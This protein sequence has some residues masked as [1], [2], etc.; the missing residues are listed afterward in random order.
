MVVYGKVD[1]AVAKTRDKAVIERLPDEF[2]QSRAFADRGW[3][4]QVEQVAQANNGAS[5]KQL[6][7][8]LADLTSVG[9]ANATTPDDDNLTAYDLRRLYYF[10]GILE[11]LKSANLIQFDSVKLEAV[12]AAIRATGSPDFD[13]PPSISKTSVREVNGEYATVL[14]TSSYSA[15]ISVEQLKRVLY[16]VN[17]P[18]VS[19]FFIEMT[20]I[21][22][23]THDSHGWLQLVEVIGTGANAGFQ[24]RTPLKFWMGEHN[25]TAFVNYD[26]VETPAAFIDSDR[27]VVVDNGYIVA[28]PDN[29]SDPS[30]PGVRL[31]TSKE[32]L[33]R[34]M[35]PTAAANLAD[36]LGWADAGENMFFEAAG[37]ADLAAWKPS[38]M[39]DRQAPPAVD[40]TEPLW[41][42]PPGNRKQIIDTA[43]KTAGELLDNAAK[44]FGT[45]ADRW[46]DGITPED[47]I[48]IST[49]LGNGLTETYES[50]FNTAVDAVRPAAVRTK[51]GQ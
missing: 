9:L 31:H 11:T 14:L 2:K 34:G 27:L 7:D 49:D 6:D 50:M 42:L 51:G 15:S 32:L 24:L 8:A 5:F 46:Q 26:M 13:K 23:L 19:S 40:T 43:Q 1:D 36:R 12:K 17:W 22:T 25:G 30:A 47:I 4:T 21:P 48:A 33:I 37:R 45:F 16:P 28:V 39:A 10:T 35:S 3:Y 44:A 41:T 20:S 38:S 18:K 29:P